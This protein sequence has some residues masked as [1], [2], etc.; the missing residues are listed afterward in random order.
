MPQNANDAYYGQN[1]DSDDGHRN[2]KYNDEG[3]DTYE[4]D[5]INMHNKRK[6]QRQATEIN[7]K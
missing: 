4:D 2:D 7:I 6:R 1:D 5:A 3:N